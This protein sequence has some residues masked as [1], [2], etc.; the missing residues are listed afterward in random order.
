MFD[1]TSQ[2]K[3]Q[4]RKQIMSANTSAAHAAAVSAVHALDDAHNAEKVVIVK[5]KKGNSRFKDSSV[6]VKLPNGKYKHVQ[7]GATTSESRLRG[8]TEVFTA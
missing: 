2:I 3:L 1:W 6:W 8:Y 7:T 4:K 5:A